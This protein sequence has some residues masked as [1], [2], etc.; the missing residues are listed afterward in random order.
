MRYI[1]TVPSRWT[2]GRDCRVAVPYRTAPCR[3]QAR[4][5]AG[6]GDMDDEVKSR[7]LKLNASIDNLKDC[8]A[9]ILAQV[10]ALAKVKRSGM[11]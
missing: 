1:I 5:E 11:E 4:R 7:S 3:T 9:Q 2:D 6:R 10:A 8:T